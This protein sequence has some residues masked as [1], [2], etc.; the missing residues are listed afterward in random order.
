LTAIIGLGLA[1][2]FQAGMNVWKRVASPS[3]SHRKAVLGLER[4]TRE[5]RSIYYYPSL[6]MSGES[7]RITFV[8]LAD[9]KIYQISYYYSSKDKCLY[10]SSQAKQNRKNSDKPDSRK[11]ISGVKSFNL[12][13]RGY[14]F[15]S[16]G[17]LAHCE[18]NFWKSRWGIPSV[19]RFELILEDGSHFKKDVFIPI[20]IV[21]RSQ[22]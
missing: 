6:K 10:R 4:L 11:I 17:R 14:Y 12:N 2:T 20:V 9:D 15:P 8:N 13:Y 5:L 21:L 18:E 22:R 19:V 3:Y 7:N 16:H 1:S